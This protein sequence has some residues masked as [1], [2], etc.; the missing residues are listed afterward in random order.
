MGA[1]QKMGWVTD[2]SSRAEHEEISHL[3][4]LLRME[5]STLP[6]W[7]WKTTLDIVATRNIGRLC[8]EINQLGCDLTQSTDHS[9]KKYVYIVLPLPDIANLTP[10]LLDN[11]PLKEP[12]ESVA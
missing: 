5:P 9:N 10:L 2:I 4:L 8:L 11:N 3:D 6:W 1:Y 12:R 7:P